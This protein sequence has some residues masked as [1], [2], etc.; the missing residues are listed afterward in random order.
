MNEHI[1]Y[2]MRN[3]EATSRWVSFNWPSELHDWSFVAIELILLV[4]VVCAGLHAWRDY[5]SSGRPS[6]LLTL[7]GALVFGLLNDIVSYYTVESFWHGEFS[8]MLLF[9]R[10]PLYISILL[11][12]LLYHVFMTIRRY[13][14]PRAVEALSVG[15]CAGVMYMIFDNLGP[16]LEWWI[17]DR[18]D[19]TNWPFF[20]AVPM[21][22]YFWLFAWTAIF[23]ALCRVVCWD[24]VQ[25]GRSSASTVAGA[26]LFPVVTCVVGIVVFIP[27]NILGLYDLH[28]WIAVLYALCFGLAGLAFVLSWRR[29]RR[30]RDPLLMVFPL[31]WAFGHL[32]L[33]AAKLD[34]YLEVDASGMTADGLAAGNP[35]V[36][37]AALI[38][39]TAI[40][41]A[42]HP[43]SGDEGPQ[44]F[45]P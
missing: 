11:A 6:G 43:P 37:V 14:F 32:F 2:A 30:P 7:L 10:L 39:F 36:A 9:N 16:M 45:L 26:F 40:T 25:A 21:T 41:L 3:T 35:L 8:V 13:D 23:A 17:W 4:G 22:S 29:P 28:A 15:F 33:Y 34:L 38:A 20:W 24:W 5:K 44:E 12:T 31:V 42:S 27:L 18:E 19:P 1:S